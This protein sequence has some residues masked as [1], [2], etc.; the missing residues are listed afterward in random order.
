MRVFTLATA[1]IAAMNGLLQGWQKAQERHLVC[2][3]AKRHRQNEDATHHESS[4]KHQAQA[5][6]LGPSRRFGDPQGKPN[7]SPNWQQKPK[8]NQKEADDREQKAYGIE[9]VL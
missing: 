2:S 4:A 7:N 8:G 3:V 6:L 9:T 1:A 5:S